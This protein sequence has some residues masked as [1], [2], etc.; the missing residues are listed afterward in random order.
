MGAL[1]NFI[2]AIQFTLPWK[3]KELDRILY[4]SSFMKKKMKLG[5]KPHMFINIH[6]YLK[7]LYA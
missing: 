2:T 5:L 7:G 3:A 4:L 6:D 1:Y